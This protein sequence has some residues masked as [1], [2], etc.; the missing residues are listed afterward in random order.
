VGR[1]RG[2]RD[3]ADHVLDRFAKSEREDV[4]ILVED[5]ADAVVAL[6]RDGLAAA[7]DRFNR[8]AARG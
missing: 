4:E 3:P 1:G 5:A 8:N 7:Q 2:G 6:I